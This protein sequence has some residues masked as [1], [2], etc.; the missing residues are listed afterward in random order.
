MHVT[1]PHNKPRIIRWSGCSHY[2]YDGTNILLYVNGALAATHSV[3]N[4]GAIVDTGGMVIGGH[5][6][7]AGRNFDGL[8]DELSIWSRTLR[9]AEVGLLFNSG[10]GITIP[11]EVTGCNRRSHP[12][13][14]LAK[15]PSIVVMR[16]MPF[17][18]QGR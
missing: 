17:I 16:L 6:N 9:A 13:L 7:G 10:D 12:H 2:R 18:D 11:T 8:V 1:T 3:T 4:G 15:P 5:R 14:L